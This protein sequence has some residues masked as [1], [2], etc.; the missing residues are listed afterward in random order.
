MDN[1]INKLCAFDKY[2]LPPILCD[3]DI[4]KCINTEPIK[5]ME[6]LPKIYDNDKKGCQEKISHTK[7]TFI[8]IRKCRKKECGVQ[9][10][11][12]Q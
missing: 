5:I 10:V 8:R 2:N 4:E 7:W 3:E 1:E 9:L 11:A 12:N 6:D